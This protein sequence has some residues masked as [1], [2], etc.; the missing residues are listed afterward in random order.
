MNSFAPFFVPIRFS[1]I[2]WYSIWIHSVFQQDEG[3]KD[4]SKQRIDLK[5]VQFTKLLHKIDIYQLQ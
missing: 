3:K 1:S 2:C 5:F 4:Y